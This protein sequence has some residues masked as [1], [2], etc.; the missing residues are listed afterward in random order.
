MFVEERNQAHDKKTPRSILLVVLVVLDGMKL[1][2]KSGSQH[3]GCIQPAIMYHGILPACATATAH[4]FAFEFDLV[5]DVMAIFN[6]KQAEV[7]TGEKTHDTTVYKVCKHVAW[8]KHAVKL[9][10]YV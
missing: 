1:V 7:S 3:A 8:S 9:W 10:Q 5:M 4:T 2:A 6:N